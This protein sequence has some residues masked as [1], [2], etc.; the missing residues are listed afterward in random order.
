MKNPS[1]QLTINLETS[2]NSPEKA[3]FAVYSLQPFPFQF[4]YP[5]QT[6]YFPF[7]LLHASHTGKKHTIFFKRSRPITRLTDCHPLFLLYPWLST[8]HRWS[9]TYHLYQ[10]DTVTLPSSLSPTYT[11]HPITPPSP[12]P[13]P[14]AFKSTASSSL[15]P[16][17]TASTTTP[18]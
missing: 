9:A 5:E 13:P 14:P 18:N 10:T 7:F 4:L 2:Q 17:Q 11:S 8:Y 16:A 1:Y 6:P 12:T 15:K 3:P